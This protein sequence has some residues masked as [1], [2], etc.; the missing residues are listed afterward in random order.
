MRS[1]KQGVSVLKAIFIKTMSISA[2]MLLAACSN[3]LPSCKSSDATDLVEQIVKRSSYRV[4]DFIELNEI[5]EVGFNKTS[6]I[7]LCVAELTTTHGVEDIN[8]SI[9]WQNKKTQQFSVEIR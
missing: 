2:I 6:E 4:G 1:A 8:Y 5:E 3:S 9:R 7:R